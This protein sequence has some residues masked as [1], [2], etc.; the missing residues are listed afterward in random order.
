MRIHYRIIIFVLSVN[1]WDK[2][3]IPLFYQDTLSDLKVIS[4]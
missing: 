2:N 3:V 1:A 4:F